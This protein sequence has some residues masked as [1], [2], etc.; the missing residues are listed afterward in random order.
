M[1]AT[2]EPLTATAAG[3]PCGSGRPLEACCLPLVEGKLPAP[4][5]EALMRSRYTAFTQTKVDYILETHHP[6]TRKEV[7]AEGIN[8]WCRRAEWLG[9]EITG[10]QGGGP[11]DETGIVSFVARYREK[12]ALVNHVEDARFERE[13]GRGGPW[14]FVTA[15]TP[16]TRRAAAKVGRND[17]CPCG[18]GKKHKKCCGAEH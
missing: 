18:S 17:P 10:T 7:S 2:P 3:C 15:S 5:A 1:T 12:G 13:G 11:A 4:T 8:D 6:S 16:P 14:R 9:L